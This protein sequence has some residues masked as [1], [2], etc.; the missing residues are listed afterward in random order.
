MT[1]LDELLA[2]TFSGGMFDPVRWAISLWLFAFGA[3]V[4][5]FMNVVIWRLPLGRGLTFPGS[6]CPNCGH[7]VRAWDNIPILNWFI[8]RGRCRDCRI[9]ISPRYP[10]VEFLVAILFV[11]VAWAEPLHADRNLPTLLASSPDHVSRM[12]SIVAVY[13]EQMLLVCTLTCA[14]F[15]WFDGNRPPRRLFVPVAVIGLIG[16][17][18]WPQLQPPLLFAGSGG[19]Q[20]AA[21]SVGELLLS[22]A[23]AFGASLCVDA[24]ARPRL[25]RSAE[26][27]A[28][29][30]RETGNRG[31]YFLG[32]RTAHESSLW[33]LAICGIVLGAT[34]LARITVFAAGL[35]LLFSGLSRAVTALRG[36][37]WT[38]LLTAALVLH[39][40]GAR[41]DALQPLHGATSDIVFILGSLGAVPLLL[42]MASSLRRKDTATP[43]GWNR[44]WPV[45]KKTAT[46]HQPHHA[47]SVEAILKSPSY[48]LAELDTDFLQRNELRPVRLQ[49]ELLKPEMTLAE[50][51]VRSTIVAFGGTQ[52]VERAEAERRL[53]LAQQALADSPDDAQLQ[54]AVRRQERLLDKSRYYDDAREFA[55]LAS[56]FCQSGRRCDFVIVTGGGPGIMEAA[57]RGAFDAGAKSIG[58]NITLPEEQ[59]PNQ[60][61]S[62]ELCFQFHYFALRKMHFV[63]RAQALVVF[64]GG[65]GTLDELFEVLTLRQ[66]NRMQA[67]PIILFGRSYWNQVLNFQFLA[68]EGVIADDHLR[69]IEY[70]ETPAEAW[71]I[72]RRFHGL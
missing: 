72:I 54:R 64:P 58:L 43:E 67:I 32:D 18:A 24:L 33:E 70:A 19:V 8:L 59:A 22:I 26:E 34:P 68:D 31:S 37:P 25:A 29:A 62:P 20:R 15:M 47:P 45:Y 4:G 27:P 11:A 61:I 57:N 7:A 46:M 63:L 42:L 50:H 23:Y 38:G 60:Y 21:A 2:R 40:V 10:A 56:S 39:L 3:C 1:T 35:Y 41:W 5:S 17:W 6:R 65:F 30:S 28:L 53:A 9:P 55:R 14:A 49:L 69:L 52:I 51:G 66:T 12:S 13:A 36:F 48:R 44:N 71:D 16:P